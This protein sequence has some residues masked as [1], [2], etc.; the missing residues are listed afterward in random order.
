M[1]PFGYLDFLF[2][3]SSWKYTENFLFPN[4]DQKICLKQI[5]VIYDS[6]QDVC[7]VVWIVYELRKNCL[8]IVHTQ[9]RVLLYSCSFPLVT[10]IWKKA[11]ELET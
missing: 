1:Y 9:S 5:Y 2:Y 10:K 7:T 11:W 6:T 4:L 3:E 8:F